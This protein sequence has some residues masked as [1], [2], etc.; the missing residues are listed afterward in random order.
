[1][2]RTFWILLIATLTGCATTS[3]PPHALASS[4]FATRGAGFALRLNDNRAIESCRYSLLLAPRQPVVSPLYLRTRFENPADSTKPFVVDSDVEPAT[5]DIHISSPEV[6]GIEARRQYKVEVIVFDS[7]DR[8]RE[9][10][11]HVQ[12]VRSNF[13]MR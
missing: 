4:F 10:G 8:I 12:Y 13:G 6:R 7:A 11:Q 9:I 2:Q 3:T 1:M 5:T